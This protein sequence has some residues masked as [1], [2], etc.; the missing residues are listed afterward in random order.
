MQVFHSTSCSIAYRAFWHELNGCRVALAVPNRW[1][2]KTNTPLWEGV[3]K[4]KSWVLFTHCY[5]VCVK[6]TASLLNSN[7]TKGRQPEGA[8]RSPPLSHPSSSEESGMGQCACESRREVVKRWT[9]PH[10]CPSVPGAFLSLGAGM[11]A[12]C[13]SKA[14]LGSAG[15]FECAVS[16]QRVR[17]SS[18]S[19]EVLKCL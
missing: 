1:C 18:E 3:L 4:I 15:H 8:A 6:L 11:W 10:C 14:L 5:Q 17:F 19:Q 2:W 9:N 16:G 7:Q 12:H 13:A